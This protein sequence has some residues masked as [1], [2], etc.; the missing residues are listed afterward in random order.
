MLNAEEIDTAGPPSIERRNPLGIEWFGQT[1][2][3][4]CW[5]ASVF[6]YGLDGAGDYLQVCAAAAWLVAN[7][8][9]AMPARRGSSSEPRDP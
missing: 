5:I 4:L 7:I 9:A 2:A 1:V 6:V 8:T 3:S